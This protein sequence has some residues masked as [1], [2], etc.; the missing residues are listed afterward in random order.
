MRMDRTETAP[1]DVT[2]PARPPGKGYAAATAF[3]AGDYKTA[4]SMQKM[5]SQPQFIKPLDD[6]T[7]KLTMKKL[8]RP[9]QPAGFEE[10]GPGRSED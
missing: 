1:T 10:H 4:N 6:A 2:K 5:D 7:A 3:D 9:Y 8:K